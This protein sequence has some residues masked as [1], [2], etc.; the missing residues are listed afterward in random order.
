MLYGPMGENAGRGVSP[1][2]WWPRPAG[3]RSRPEP[4][5]LEQR[6]VARAAPSVCYSPMSHREQCR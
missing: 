2:P 3:V 5:A 6:E 4:S 1:H